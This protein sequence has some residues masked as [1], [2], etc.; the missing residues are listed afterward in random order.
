MAALPP[1]DDDI[2]DFSVGMN[3]PLGTFRLDRRAS[4]P[5]PG[6]TD[7]VDVLPPAS[8]DTKDDS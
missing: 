7:H 1:P 2:D 4:G 3:T 5:S 8:T 6:E